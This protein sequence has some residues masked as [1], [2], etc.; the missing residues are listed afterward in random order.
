M[1]KLE[2]PGFL[3][4]W[5]DKNRFPLAVADHWRPWYL[6]P[7]DTPKVAEPRSPGLPKMWLAYP[8]ASMHPGKTT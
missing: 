7:E 2:Y 5:Q 3:L 4:W 8:A 6:W 1:T